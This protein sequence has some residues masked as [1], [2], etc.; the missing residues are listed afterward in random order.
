MRDINK[1]AIF[2]I[3]GDIYNHL[4]GGTLCDRMVVSELKKQSEVRL[5][6]PQLKWLFRFERPLLTG[7]LNNLRNLFRHFP[8]GALLFINHGIYRDCF[9]AANVWK[10][11]YGCRVI[12]LVYHLD[13][14]LPQI[15]GGK[16]L[17]IMIERL[18]INVYDFALTISRST[19]DHLERLG[20]PS[21]RIDLIPVSR[22]FLPQALS[23]RIAGSTVVFLF[24][25]TVE[26]RKGLSD[27]VEALARYRGSSQI[28]FNCV[29]KCDRSDSYVRKLIASAEKA[30]QLRLSLLGPISQ[31]SLIGQFR[32]ADAFLF[33]SHW[34]GYGIAIEEAMCFGLPVIAYR[35]GA[36]PELVEDGSTG[37]LVAAGDIDGLAK[38]I[39]Q[40]VDDPV[41]RNRRGEMGRRR[42][43]QIVQEHDLTG[44]LGKAIA[45]VNGALPS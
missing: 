16:A 32:A 34:E 2:F 3:T 5:I 7:L 4:T 23:R 27:A 37:W 43:A 8:R 39:A 44:I 6:L 24:V 15:K 14:E 21:S 9:L 40:C 36:V 33:P 29:G 17:R 19:A 12:G 11:I 45:E 20:Q 42:A 31:E 41:E 30:P 18:M 35:A 10:C 1:K 26:P 25:G 38:A 28:I 13:Y 22:R